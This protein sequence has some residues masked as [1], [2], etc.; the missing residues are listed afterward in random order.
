MGKTIFQ[1]GK[2]KGETAG[3]TSAVGRRWFLSSGSARKKRLGVP[4]VTGKNWATNLCRKKTL[5]TNGP[6]EPPTRP[7]TKS[8]PRDTAEKRE[9]QL[10]HLEVEKVNDILQTLQS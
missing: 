5:P 4:D 8:P 6:T 2:G 9:G 3:G 1:S 10:H 7:K